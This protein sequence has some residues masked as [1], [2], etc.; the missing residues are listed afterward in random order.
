MA[1]SILQR[2]AAKDKT[3]AQ[4]CL[5]AYGGL[6]WSLARRMCANP[7]DAED[8]VQEIFIDIWK[9]AERFDETQASETTF[10]AMIARRRLIDR[11]RKSQ[12][13]PFVDSIEDMT[14]EPLKAQ[15]KQMQTVVE[16]KQAAEAMRALRPEQRRVLQ[17][18]IY[19]GMSHQEI[20]EA[21]GMP[22]GTVKSHAR[23]GLMQIREVLGLGS[24]GNETKGVIA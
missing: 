22:V 14:V 16:A 18:S 3:A 13:Q 6:V 17:L 9:N 19:Q 5:N 23:R 15:D 10:V 7:N 11:L 1:R 12:R 8:A 4:E 2:I 21:T 20:A 24:S